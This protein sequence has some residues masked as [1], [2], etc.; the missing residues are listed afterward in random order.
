MGDKN[1]M[2]CFMKEKVVVEKMVYLK[3]EVRFVLY[4]DNI[5][6][7]RKKNVFLKCFFM[8]DVKFVLKL[9]K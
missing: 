7:N 6:C 3:Y 1:E 4:L 2:E 5:R 8:L 9:F